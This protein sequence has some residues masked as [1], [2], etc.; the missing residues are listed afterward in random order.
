MFNK[1]KINEIVLV[2][3]IGKITNKFIYKK[4]KIVEKD[5]YYKDYLVKLED[6]T[7]DWFKESDIKKI[8]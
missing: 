2:I 1:F 6:A 7:E 5:D 4:G 8:R 3:G